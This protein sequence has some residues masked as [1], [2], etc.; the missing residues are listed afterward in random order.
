MAEWWEQI[1][2]QERNDERA[3]LRHQREE[4]EHGLAELR[5]RQPR[6]W[7][8]ERAVRAALENMGNRE[9]VMRTLDLLS[10]SLSYDLRKATPEGKM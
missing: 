3:S 7:P 9:V 10:K 8:L 1:N 2:A 6:D 5:K 4:L